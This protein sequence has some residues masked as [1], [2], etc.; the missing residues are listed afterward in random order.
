MH[1]QVSSSTCKNVSD[2]RRC[3]SELSCHSRNASV[4][5]QSH[6]SRGA[7]RVSVSQPIT[8]LCALASRR[9]TVHGRQ[10]RVVQEFWF[11]AHY[12]QCFVRAVLTSSGSLRE[13]MCSV[14]SV[15]I[16]DAPEELRRL[17]SLP[18]SP[19]LSLWRVFPLARSASALRSCWS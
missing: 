9:A 3:E 6:C 4:S 7:Q 18:F 2:C 15:H 19:F 8:K 13:A 16:E 11:S 14:L 1:K 12:H 10:E 17:P 5:N